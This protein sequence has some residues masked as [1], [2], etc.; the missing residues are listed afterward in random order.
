MKQRKLLFKQIIKC[1]DHHETI[2]KVYED[3]GYFYY[4]CG[5]CGMIVSLD[6]PQKINDEEKRFTGKYCN[7]IIKIF[8][9]RR[10]LNG[11]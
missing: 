4:E 10:R 1:P 3:N 7:E 5:S 2:C 9:K 11:N 8:D 6:S